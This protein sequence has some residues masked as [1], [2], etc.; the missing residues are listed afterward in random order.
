M[1]RASPTH[2]GRMACF[3]RRYALGDQTGITL[4]EAQV[5]ESR[6][7]ADGEAALVLPVYMLDHSELS[8]S[9]T[10]FSCPFDSGKIGIIF[11]TYNSIRKEYG[12][13][14]ISKR[15][16]AAARDRLIAEVAEYNAEL[17]DGAD[18]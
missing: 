8:V 18:E 15:L 5:I 9:T 4:T 14:R 13:K 1:R 11:A 12:K 3:H 10:R 7:E 17:Q 6:C 2:L 16:L